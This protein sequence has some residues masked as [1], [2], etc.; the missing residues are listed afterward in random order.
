MIRS[1]ILVSDEVQESVQCMS[2]IPDRSV[3]VRQKE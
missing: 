3:D 2:P 1:F